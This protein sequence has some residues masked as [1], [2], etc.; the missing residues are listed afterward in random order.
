MSMSFD[1]PESEWPLEGFGFG[2]IS[3]A[4]N[5]GVG[6][7]EG[8]RRQVTMG[9]IQTQPIGAQQG[10]SSGGPGGGLLVE[11]VVVRFPRLIDI[12]R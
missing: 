7:A 6:P 10:K 2:A 3:G 5:L 12:S 9:L 8:L 11:V 4:V 1:D